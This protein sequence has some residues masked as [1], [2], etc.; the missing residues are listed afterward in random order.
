MCRVHCR[1]NLPYV[2]YLTDES[3]IRPGAPLAYANAKT[4]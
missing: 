1:K 2:S 4:L 3:Y